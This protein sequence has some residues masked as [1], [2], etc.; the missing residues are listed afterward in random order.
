MVYEEWSAW[1][2]EQFLDRFHQKSGL[3]TTELYQAMGVSGYKHV[4]CWRKVGVFYLRMMA[5]ALSYL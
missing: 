5:P 2:D 3:T 1:S 4:G